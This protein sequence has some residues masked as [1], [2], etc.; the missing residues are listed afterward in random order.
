MTDRSSDAPLSEWLRS[1]D[2]YD[3]CQRYRHAQDIVAAGP[4]LPTA[5]EAFEE[6]QR[7]I[8]ARAQPSEIEQQ[9]GG[10]RAPGSSALCVVVPLEPTEAMLKAAKHRDLNW[11]PSSYAD[12]YKAMISAAPVAATPNT[13][14][15]K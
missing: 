11:S 12:I 6:M 9:D 15:D 3:L 5:S 8:L 14:K 1:Q 4:G 13:T 10:G 2:F 7:E